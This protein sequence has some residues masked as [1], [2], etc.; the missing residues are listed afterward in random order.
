MTC[1]SSFFKSVA[2]SRF[3]SVI[4]FS[5][6]DDVPGIFPL[7]PDQDHHSS[8][9]KTSGDDPGLSVISPLINLINRE[10]CEDLRRIGEVDL[11]L[12]KSR[13]PLLRIERDLHYLCT[14][15]K[16]RCQGAASMLLASTR[17]TCSASLPDPSL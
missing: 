7:C 15:N 1:S 9:K 4:C 3:F 6:G 16:Y 8:F 17:A 13:F 5:H 12:L 2:V 14:H 10:A 11:P